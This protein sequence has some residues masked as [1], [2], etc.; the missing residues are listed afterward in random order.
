MAHG[1][2][3]SR[4]RTRRGGA[5]FFGYSI[6]GLD[7]RG[8]LWIE[9]RAAEGGRAALMREGVGE[10]APGFDARTRVH[11]YGGGAVWTHG[12]TVFQSSFADGRIYRVDAG[13]EPYPVTRSR[14]RRTRCATPTAGSRPTAGP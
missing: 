13:G 6:V 10:V 3:R 8:L 14:R 12:D 9:Q 2:R 11:E 5:P 1:G 7:E 4:S